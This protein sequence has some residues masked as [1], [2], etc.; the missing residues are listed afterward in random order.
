MDG[1]SAVTGREHWG[2][3]ARHWHPLGKG[4]AMPTLG[5]LIQ[6]KRQER[7]LTQQE[8]GELIGTTAVYVSHIESGATAWPRRYIG[9]LAMVLGLNIYEMAEAAGRIP[10]PPPTRWDHPA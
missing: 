10:N 7:G 2:R 4:I 9:P 3:A 1:K 5:S 6:A 8:L